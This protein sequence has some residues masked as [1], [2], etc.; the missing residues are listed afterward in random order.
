VAWR[1]QREKN[2]NKQTAEMK[3]EYNNSAGKCKK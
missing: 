2:K 3:Y 1:G